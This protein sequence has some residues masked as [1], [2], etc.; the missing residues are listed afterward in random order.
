MYRSIFIIHKLY[1]LAIGPILLARKNMAR[2][3]PLTEHLMHEV[4]NL[5]VLLLAGS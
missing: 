1:I 3:C 4:C 2:V 5:E